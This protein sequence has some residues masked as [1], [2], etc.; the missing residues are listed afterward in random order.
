MTPLDASSCKIINSLQ[1]GFP[2]T[3]RPFLTAAQSL[4]MSEEELI[5]KIKEL[6]KTGFLTRFGP[7]FNAE[8]MGGGLTLAALA[9]PAERYEQVTEMV[10]SFPEVAHNYAREHTLNMWFVLATESRSEIA[11]VIDKI[12]KA[13]GL[14]VFN[15]PKLEEYRLGFKLHISPDGSIDTTRLEDSE[16]LFGKGDGSLPTPEDRAI[17]TATQEGLPFIPTPYDAVAQQVALP[18]KSVLARFEHMLKQGWVRRLGVVPNHYKL[19]LSSN[20][21]TVWNL[22]EDKV[23]S[24]GK[25]IG[26]LDFVSHCYRRP[27]N[28]PE[29]PYNLFVMVHGRNRDIVKGRVAKISEMLGEA[30]QGH[31]ILYSTRILKKTGLR[32]K[33]ES[34]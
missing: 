8:Q 29:W 17:I 6:L 1:T 15:L 24:S 21:M 23:S 28:P 22:P 27:R 9:V 5:A 11:T 2:L 12:E 3:T 26:D 20:G 19:G 16:S 13:T 18:T 4:E 30:D 10:N 14:Q 33:R 7:L 25:L 31:K 32:I 34:N